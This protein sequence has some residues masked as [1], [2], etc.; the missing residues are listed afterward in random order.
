MDDSPSPKLGGKVVHE[1]RWLGET[2]VDRQGRVR[3]EQRQFDLDSAALFVEEAL[4]TEKLQEWLSVSVMHDCLTGINGLYN[5]LLL[6][7]VNDSED[8]ATSAMDFAPGMWLN[9]LPNS[10]NSF[11]AVISESAFAAADVA[12]SKFPHVSKI[13]DPPMSLADIERFQYQNV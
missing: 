3:G 7:T 1:L 11:G 4:A 6:G 5:S 2:P 9:P 8:L 12:C 10:G 13:E